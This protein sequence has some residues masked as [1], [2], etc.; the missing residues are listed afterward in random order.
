MGYG[1]SV[2]LAGLVAVGVW[3]LGGGAVMVL[4]L[5]AIVLAMGLVASRGLTFDRPAR[6]E[7]MC[8]H[9]TAP[10]REPG[11]SGEPGPEP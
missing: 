8:D 3:A 5:A 9:V 11:L 1:V 7:R 2:G 10:G 6:R 4:A